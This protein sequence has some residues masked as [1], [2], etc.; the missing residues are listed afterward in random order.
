M[1]F[2]TLLSD[3]LFAALGVLFA[4]TASGTVYEV[5]GGL[6]GTDPS[7]GVVVV[8]SAAAVWGHLWVRRFC[9]G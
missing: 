6:T 3:S 2:S 7:G 9:D 4:M 1:K 5:Q 8:G